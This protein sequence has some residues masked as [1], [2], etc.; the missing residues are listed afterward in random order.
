M[1]V[2]PRKYKG[3]LA[4]LFMLVHGVCPDQ[5]AWL[6]IF[7]LCYFYHETDS[8]ALHLKN[9][10]HTLDG[11][12]I[13]RNPT[14][15]AILVYNPQNQRYYKPDSYCIDPYHL[16]SLVYLTIKYDGGLFVSFH[17]D[18]IASISEPY[19]PGTRVAK[20]N[21]TTGHT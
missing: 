7:S 5:I 19:P 16:P 14:S 8:N 4:S 2:V 12:I 9:Q 3:K 17:K 1:N 10:A 18:E 6:P 20:V 21:P 15:M 13:G 11:I